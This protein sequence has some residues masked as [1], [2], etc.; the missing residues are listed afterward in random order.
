MCVVSHSRASSASEIGDGTGDISWMLTTRA[1]QHFLVDGSKTM[2]LYKEKVADT[3]WALAR[4]L[5]SKTP[6]PG[7][8]NLSVVGDNNPVVYPLHAST[9]QA[10]KIVRN[11]RFGDSRGWV[12]QHRYVSHQ[13]TASSSP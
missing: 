4:L 7:S 11:F 3:V 8:L 12:L 6:R 9:K 13:P 2:E 1:L 5:K 10:H